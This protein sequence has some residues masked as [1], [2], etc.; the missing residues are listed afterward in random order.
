MYPCKHTD[1]PIKPKNI[2]NGRCLLMIKPNFNQQLFLAELGMIAMNLVWLAPILKYYPWFN[3]TSR[4]QPLVTSINHTHGS[5][6]NRKCSLVFQIP[7]WICSVA[8]FHQAANC[9]GLMGKHGK[10]RDFLWGTVGCL[11]S[12]FPWNKSIHIMLILFTH[13]YLHYLS[14]SSL[15]INI[16]Y[17]Y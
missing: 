14:F 17:S 2:S 16:H 8:W 11:R 5:L 9:G 13:P 6:C 10:P 4:Q 7:S 3:T 15:F 12:I 1:T